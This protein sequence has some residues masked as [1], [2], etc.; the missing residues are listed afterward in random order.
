MMLRLGRV[1]GFLMLVIVAAIP[2]LLGA[3][4]LPN[5]FGDAYVYIRDIGTLSTKIKA[6]TFALTDLYG[7]WLP[8]YQFISAIANV[9][10]GNGFYTGKIVSALAGVGVCLLVYAITLRVVQNQTAALLSFLLIAMNPLHIMNSASAMTDVPHA[11][12]VLTSL[13]FVLNKRW[14][15]AAMFAALAGLTRVESWMLIALLP[16]IQFWKERRVSIPAILIM[17]FAPLFWFYVS[18]KATG[19]WLACFKVRE[20]YKEWLLTQNPALA[21]FSVRGVI[22]DT[23]LLVS[24]IDLAVLCAALVAGWLV[25]RRLT[26]RAVADGRVA[27]VGAGNEQLVSPNIDSVLPVL[28]FFFPFLALLIVAY[29][30][31]QQSIIFPRYGLI[32]FSLGIPILAW[33]YFAIVRRR[34]QWSRR[35]LIA[36]V[37]L[38]AVNFSAQFA[39]GVGELNRYVA[40]RRVADYL[41]DHFDLNSKTKIFCDE[42]AVRALS[43]IAEDRFVSSADV[44]KDYEGF[45]PALGEKNVEWLV[46][47]PQPGS[48]PAKLFP[49]FEGGASIGTFESVTQARSEFLPINI[50]VYRR[51]Q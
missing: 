6:G 4:F 8:L 45:W 3:L 35:I 50:H 20:Q 28:V 9:F 47:A 31:H 15:L 24:G 26:R 32:L 5:T 7:F 34:P 39:G 33:T 12:L 1:R 37:L 18:W 19:D 36:I 2:R 42:G 14:M 22:Q 43:G 44:P 10:V 21:E 27:N 23:A 25:M 48:T 41:R 49:Q 46:I 38:C 17:L 40:Q 16:T 29:L 13:Y 11:L 51:I 30:T